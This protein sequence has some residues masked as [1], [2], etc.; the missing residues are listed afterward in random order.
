M[1]YNTKMTQKI[2]TEPT[3]PF[4]RTGIKTFSPAE[5]NTDINIIKKGTI[6]RMATQSLRPDAKHKCIRYSNNAYKFARK[7]LRSFLLWKRKEQ[8]DWNRFVSN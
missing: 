8:K 6:D 4:F 2:R 3:S 5:N 7:G 1:F